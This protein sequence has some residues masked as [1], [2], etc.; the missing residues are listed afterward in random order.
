M[1]H[2]RKRF[3]F[4]RIVQT[5]AQFLSRFFYPSLFDDDGSAN[6]RERLM[7]QIEFILFWIAVIV[8]MFGFSVRR[9][10]IRFMPAFFLPWASPCYIVS[11]TIVF[12]IMCFI[13]VRTF[14]LKRTLGC[15]Y[16]LF[17]FMGFYIFLSSLWS[18]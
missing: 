7:N 13:L 18:Y 5:I 8:A 16:M 10:F 1:G 14:L 3:F 11:G 15:I 12:L 4:E 9:V 6:P 17:I 2:D